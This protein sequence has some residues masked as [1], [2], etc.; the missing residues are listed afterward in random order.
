MLALQQKKPIL[1]AVKVFGAV[2]DMTEILERVLKQQG[3]EVEEDDDEEENE[4]EE[5]EKS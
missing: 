4:D 1:V 3:E 2:E 5:E